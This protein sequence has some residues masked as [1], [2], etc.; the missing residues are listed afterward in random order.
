MKMKVRLGE[1]TFDVEVGDLRERPIVALVDG[2]RFEVWPEGEAAP[3]PA[4]PEPAAQPA[5]AA[6][7]TP[8]KPGVNGHHHTQLAPIP[9]II[10]TVSVRP[11]MTVTPGQTLCVLEAMK[12][13]NSIRANQAGKVATVHMSAGQH[14]KH[15]DVLVE[16]EE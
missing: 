4:K 9:G 8:V 14:V 16:Y 3:A 2:E 10:R 12:M 7:P 6:P 15:G 11:G 13:N 1:Q 5:Q